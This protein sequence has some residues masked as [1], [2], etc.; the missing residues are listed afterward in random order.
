MFYL[1]A[2]TL[3]TSWNFIED[4]KLFIEGLGETF[5]E[6]TSATPQVSNETTANA[7]ASS[8]LNEIAMIVDLAMDN[9]E[10]DML[11]G[12]V[13]ESGK[14]EVIVYLSLFSC[15]LS[16]PQANQRKMCWMT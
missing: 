5:Q 1:D 8:E 16:I 10:R 4:I 13:T 14:V 6:N 3:E 11:T 12:N 9:V 2:Q 7:S 15:Q